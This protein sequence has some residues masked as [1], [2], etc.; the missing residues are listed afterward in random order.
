MSDM[1]V[2]RVSHYWP[3]LGGINCLSFINGICMSNM[4]SGEPWQPWVGSAA[5]CPPEWPFW[6]RFMLT[7]GEWFTCLD[8]GGAIIDN[9]VDLLVEVPPVPFGTEMDVK[10]LWR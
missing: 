10:V 8:R 7:G 2:V 6:T 1:V 3:P 9:W 4:A 5:A